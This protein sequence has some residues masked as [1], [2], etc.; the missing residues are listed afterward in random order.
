LRQTLAQLKTEDIKSLYSFEYCTV[1][2]MLINKS[3]SLEYFSNLYQD[4]HSISA[5]SIEINALV[6]IQGGKSL[7]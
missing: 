2:L 3:D 7:L 6:W 4:A 5:L 1:I